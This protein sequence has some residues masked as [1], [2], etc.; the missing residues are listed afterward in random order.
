MSIPAS[1]P[2]NNYGTSWRSV[3]I[4]F[5][6]S[7]QAIIWEAIEAID[8][9][10]VTAR[11][12]PIVIVGFEG[13]GWLPVHDFVEFIQ[14]GHD[15][16]VVVDPRPHLHRTLARIEA[17]FGDGP[18]INFLGIARLDLADRAAYRAWLAALEDR[19]AENWFEMPVIEF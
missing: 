1:W 11:L 17:D 9:L 6:W 18:W 12:R 7:D 16:C 10:K 19:W 3:T 15:T 8:P 14:D 5:D 13:D 2:T 4:W